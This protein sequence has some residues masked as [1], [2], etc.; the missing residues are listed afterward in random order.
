[1]IATRMVFTGRQKSECRSQNDGNDYRNRPSAENAFA[2]GRAVCRSFCILTSD[3]CIPTPPP[4]DL[5][6]PAP[7]IFVTHVTWA[8]GA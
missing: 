4:C 1:M 7:L 2:V 5:R 8:A 3:F 6:H